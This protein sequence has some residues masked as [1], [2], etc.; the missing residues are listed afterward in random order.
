[1]GAGAAVGVGT[2]V[3][4]GVGV[5]VGDG[6]GT[7]VGVAVGD[8]VGTRVGIGVG[9]AVNVFWTLAATVASMFGVT[10]GSTSRSKQPA[11]SSIAARRSAIAG[12]RR[13][14]FTPTPLAGCRQSADYY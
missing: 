6:V 13:D 5:A 4:T 12:K 9:A 7:G 1:M 10:V 3:G 11:A 8:G 2:R 14:L